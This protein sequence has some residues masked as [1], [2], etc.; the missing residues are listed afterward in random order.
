MNYTPGYTCEENENINL[1]RYVYPHAHY[2][3]IF[4]SQN[5]KTS[6]PQWMNGQRRCGTVQLTLEQCEGLRVLTLSPVKNPSITY[7]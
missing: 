7:S 5:L 6:V 3:I 2:S 4:N 1:K